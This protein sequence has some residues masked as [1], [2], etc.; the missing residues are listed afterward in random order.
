MCHKKN[1]PSV[2]YHLFEGMII[3]G[4]RLW[5]RLSEG[6][7]FTSVRGETERRGQDLSGCRHRRRR[8]RSAALI[9]PGAIP[10]PLSSSPHYT[11]ALP[12]V[13]F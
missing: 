9:H 3:A 1:H 13:P 12:S 7:M 8:R 4:V 11:L 2:L 5:K 10:L 6:I